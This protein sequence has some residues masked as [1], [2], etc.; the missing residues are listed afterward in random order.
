[1]DSRK[2]VF[3]E[4]AWIALGQAVG[5]AAM[6]GVYALLGRF[7]VKVLLGGLIG[8]G[9]AILNFLIMGVC[10][11]IAADRASAQNVKGGKTLL[12]LSFLIR[13]VL[14][15]LAL[16]LGAKSGMCDIIALAVPLLFVRPTLTLE[17]FFRKKE[18]QNG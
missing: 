13:Y 10:V 15:F 2:M 11:S 8:A 3:R 17:E 12:H 16:F 5:V 7:S 14:I 4:T 1:M 6:F 9:L 18:D